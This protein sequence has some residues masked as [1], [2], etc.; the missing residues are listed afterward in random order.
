MPLKVLLAGCS[1]DERHRLETL[2]RSVIGSRAQEG[3]WN[4]SLVKVANKWSAHVDGPEAPLKGISFIAGE[5]ELRDKILDS[6]R[7][8]GGGKA[9]GATAAPT[10]PVSAASAGGAA[11][12]PTGVVSAPPPPPQDSPAVPAA[13]AKPS[14]PGEQ[15]DRYACATCK[16]PFAVVFQSKPGEGTRNVPVACPHCWQ[17]NQV[18]VGQ[19]AAVGEEFRA[20][21]EA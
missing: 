17:L 1:K 11:A 9:T 20:E 6:I 15:R 18:P 5:D 2:V 21:K 14:V 13:P 16:R 19:W 4:V 7:N 3:A 8:A 12:P 10:A